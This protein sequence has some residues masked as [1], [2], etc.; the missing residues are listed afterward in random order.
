M[1]AAEPRQQPARTRCCAVRCSRARGRIRLMPP[2]A[3][4]SFSC[5]ASSL[6]ATMQRTGEIAEPASSRPALILRWCCLWACRAGEGDEEG[7]G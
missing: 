6:T 3:S 2:A 4:S 1:V 5:T 7:R